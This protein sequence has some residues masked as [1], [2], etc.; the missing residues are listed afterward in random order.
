VHY[1]GVVVGD[2]VADRL[3]AETVLVELKAVQALVSAH[4]LQLPITCRRPAQRWDC[5]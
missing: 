5:F 3:V 4:E 1:Q 2:F